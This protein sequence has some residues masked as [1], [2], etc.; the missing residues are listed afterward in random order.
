MKG[1]LTSLLFTGM[2]IMINVHH[3]RPRY[4][5]FHLYLHMIK[6]W[7]LSSSSKYLFCFRWTFDIDPAIRKPLERRLIRYCFCKSS[8]FKIL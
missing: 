4:E 7:N 6:A 2:R 3:F 1:N 8:H 5:V